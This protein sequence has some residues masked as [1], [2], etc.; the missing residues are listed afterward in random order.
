MLDSDEIQLASSKGPDAPRRRK[1]GTLYCWVG[2]EGWRW[3]MR[4]EDPYLDAEGE[5]PPSISSPLPHVLPPSPFRF[6]PPAPSIERLMQ[7]FIRIA[8]RT[9]DRSRSFERAA[10]LL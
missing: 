7:L 1:T 2:V 3:K 10:A 5:L 6:N 8:H 4:T 9:R